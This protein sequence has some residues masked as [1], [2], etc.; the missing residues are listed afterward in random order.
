MVVYKNGDL[1]QSDCKII[2][3]QV[4]CRGVMGAGIAKV[5]RTKYPHAYDV[6]QTSYRA[7]SN[8]LGEIDV[9]YIAED[10]R[11]IINMYAQYDY[12]PK[13]KVHTDY[14]AFAS[15]VRKLKTEVSDYKKFHPETGRLNIGFPSHIGCGLAGGNWETVKAILEREFCGDEWNVEIWQLKP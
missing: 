14:E 15:C 7:G 5:I 2:C 12:R 13:G 8:V 6:F 10:K 9:V 4:N 3:H 11:F 1:L